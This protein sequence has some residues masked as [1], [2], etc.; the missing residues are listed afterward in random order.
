M[1]TKTI[2]ADMSQDN[3]DNKAL[4]LIAFI[5]S[6][7]EPLVGIIAGSVALKEYRKEG[8]TQTWKPLALAG[9]I[10][11]YVGLAIR[12]QIVIFFMAIMSQAGHYNHYNDCNYNYNYGYGYNCVYPQPMPYMYDSMMSNAM[13]AEPVYD[14][15]MDSMGGGSTGVQ[16]PSYTEPYMITK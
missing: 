9:T 7:I 12:I 15:P 2:E 14:M 3:R 5:G 13:P 4:T 16:E 8:A 6:F 10:I 11:G 1:A